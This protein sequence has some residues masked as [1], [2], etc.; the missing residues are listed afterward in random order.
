MKGAKTSIYLLMVLLVAVDSV[1]READYIPAL[2]WRAFGAS[3]KG[4]CKRYVGA[5]LLTLRC[6]T[7]VLWPVSILTI[8]GRRLA[9]IMSDVS[10]LCWQHAVRMRYRFDGSIDCP[11]RCRMGTGVGLA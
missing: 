4:G 8:V 7:A 1:W 5:Y 2:V 10:I 6:L 9:M 3:M 11:Q